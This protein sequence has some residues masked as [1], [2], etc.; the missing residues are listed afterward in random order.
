MV[1]FSAIIRLR[2]CGLVRKLSTSMNWGKKRAMSSEERLFSNGFKSK[3]ALPNGHRDLLVN[4]EPVIYVL[5]TE[6][7]HSWMAFI[8]AKLV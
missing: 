8:Q 3:P 7:P 1:L 5:L 2:V 6:T 4:M